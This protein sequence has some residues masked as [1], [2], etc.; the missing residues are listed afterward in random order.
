MRWLQALIILAVG[1]CTN[2]SLA[3]I[4]QWEWINPNDHSLGRQQSTFLAPDGSGLAPEPGLYAVEKDLTGAY[5]AGFDLTD[6]YL[7]RSLLTDAYA[8]SAIFR[9]AYLREVNLTGA[10]LSNADLHSAILWFA[11]LTGTNLSNAAL[12]DSQVNGAKLL[13][14][15]LT[16]ADIS[17]ADLGGTTRFGFTA[18]QLYST[19]NYHD[20]NLAGVD[21]SYNDLSA[22]SFVEQNLVDSDL[23][24]S[25]LSETDFS[26]S[27]LRGNHIGGSILNGARFVGADLRDVFVSG[28]GAYGVGSVSAVGANFTSAQLQ[29]IHMTYDNLSGAIYE[30]ADLTEAILVGSDLIG[31]DFQHS[32]AIEANLRGANLQGANFTGADLTGA[33]LRGAD[34]RAA[35][36]FDV[37]DT[38]SDNL[39]HPDGHIDKFVVLE[40]MP[41]WD[42][43]PD[44]V[45][46]YGGDRV[47][48]I[49]IE[50][51]TVMSIAEDGELWIQLED[52]EWN[53]P[54]TF[55]PGI[56]VELDGTLHLH[57][58]SSYFSVPLDP[59]KFVGSTFQIFDWTS[60]EPVGVFN[61]IGVPYDTIWDTSQL[62]TTGEIT[63]VGLVP[64]PTMWLLILVLSLAVMCHYRAV[65]A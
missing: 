7:Y 44:Q 27:N 31:A 23:G 17:G 65:K 47:R 55:A 42:F 39:I 59:S 20:R 13:S 45:Q 50:V 26:K 2:S 25:N 56:P 21:L 18:E 11:D 53:S 12:V 14:A 19:A 29:S 64:E 6:S 32:T 3:D 36:G 62:Y 24:L 54:I 22:W 37:P 4:Y 51:R 52:D 35:Q 46:Q 40:S 58:G 28:W 16:G 1:C 63:F 57:F 15:D 9:D 41:V 8:S 10:D 34:A 38:N 60:V 49:P 61:S 43:N 5:L 30:D 48:E 33:I